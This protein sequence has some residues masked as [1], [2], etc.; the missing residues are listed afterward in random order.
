MPKIPKKRKKREK[1]AAIV[2]QNKRVNANYVRKG[3]GRNRRDR[4][5]EGEL[6]RTA[7]ALTIRGG[8]KSDGTS[9]GR[10]AVG[11]ALSL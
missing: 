2:P 1:K 6:D 7:S 11:S 3:T 10:E 8:R 9:Q 5:R 4:G